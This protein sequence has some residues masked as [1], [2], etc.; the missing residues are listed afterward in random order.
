MSAPNRFGLRGARLLRE[1]WWEPASAST[2]DGLGSRS[3]YAIGRNYEKHA[4]ELGNA[5]PKEPFWFLKPIASVVGPGEKHIVFP[6]RSES[7]HEVEIGI[8]I[9]KMGKN[10]AVDKAA[11]HIGGL[12]LGLDMTDRDGQAVV[13]KEGKPWTQCKGWDTSLPVSNLARVD[14]LVFE[15]SDS[16]ADLQ[17]MKLLSNLEFWLKVNGVEK[18]RGNT[19][20]MVS[21]IA[22]Q[23]AAISRIHR[24]DPGDIVLTGTP[25]GVGACKPGDV[26]TAGIEGCDGVFDIEVEVASDGE[27]QQ[28]TKRPKMTTVG[29][30]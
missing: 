15:G 1:K 3:I 27:L 14:D 5:V 22:E 23:L 24:L 12:F 29:S 6:G 28:L 25:E 17:I 11:Q 19:N 10:I 8:V 21:N 26:I 16:A 30:V 18:Q 7:H 9:G 4:K 20:D 13:K 2:P